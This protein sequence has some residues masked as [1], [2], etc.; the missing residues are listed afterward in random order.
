LLFLAS[1]SPKANLIERL[2]KFMKRETLR[3]RYYADYASIGHSVGAISRL[4]S[5]IC[6]DSPFAYTVSP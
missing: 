4:P 3:G 5:R 6:G 2:W 1:Y